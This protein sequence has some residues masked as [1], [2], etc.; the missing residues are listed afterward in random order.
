MQSERGV[1]GAAG[2]GGE[3]VKTGV[4]GRKR[5]IERE[6][7]RE[8][9]RK[10][11]TERDRERE[12]QKGRQRTLSSSLRPSA[13]IA[14]CSPG[15]LTCVCVCVRVRVCVCVS[16][17]VC[18]RVWMDGK[19]DGFV[20]IALALLPLESNPDICHEH[21]CM[22]AGTQACY[23]C[24]DRETALSV[25]QESS[26]YSSKKCGRPCSQTQARCANS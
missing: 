2:V 22:H 10:R 18:V 15:T 9:E 4:K 23:M 13:S 21:E 16:V 7:E 3:G 11:E 1:E 20:G 26:G 8:K 5:E 19:I 14:S 6:R 24:V 25:R 12:R 17:C